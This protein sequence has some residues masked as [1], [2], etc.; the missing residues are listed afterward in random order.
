MNITHPYHVITKPTGAICNLDCQYCFYLS[1]QQLYPDIQDFRMRD[2]VLERYIKQYLNQPSEEITFTW[3]GGEPTLMGLDFYK[4]V[5]HLQKIYNTDNKTI[6]NSLQT[7]GIKL[8]DEWAAFFHDHD[9][10]IGVSIDGPEMYHNKYRY[11][12]G[13]K[14][15][16]EKVMRGIECLRQHNVEYNILCCLNRDNADHPFE[17]YE[18]F[19]SRAGTPYWQFIPIVEQS[20]TSSDGV[21]DYSIKPKQYAQFLTQLFNRWV[22]RDIG[23]ISIQIFDISLRSF[24]GLN[25]GLCLFEETC[26]S[27]L[28]I[29]HNGDLYSCDH[30]V[31]PDYKLGNIMQESM[32]KMVVKDQQVEFGLNKK[33]TLPDYCR[34]CEVQSLCNGGCPKNR[35]IKTPDGSPGL[36]YLCS[37]YKT[38]FK[39]ITPYMQFLS[40]QL[41]AGWT[42]QDIMNYINAYPES[43][44][45]KEPGRNNLCYC[46][47]GKKFKK[48]CGS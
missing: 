34:E 19:K 10:L 8:N 33:D 21:S 39:H 43:F 5:V 20:N 7:N 12:K 13:G 47:S 9:F 16:H 38:F 3:Q 31:D 42:V 48:C 15:S 44:V 26:G 11:F 41:N 23:T 1:K 45:H 35:F 25:P 14:K 22:R 17:L 29:E 18:F 24:M 36:N 2:D 28:A 46:G 37:A 32:N 40:S 30:Y 27:A 6:Y 4:K